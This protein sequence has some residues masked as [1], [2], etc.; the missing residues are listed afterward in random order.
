MKS[1][2]QSQYIQLFSNAKAFS[3]ANPKPIFRTETNLPEPRMNVFCAHGAS[4]RQRPERAAASRGMPARRNMKITKRTQFRAGK[5]RKS[6]AETRES[7]CR[8]PARLPPAALAPA[9]SPEIL[10]RDGVGLEALAAGGGGHAQALA[11]GGG[12]LVALQLLECLGEGVAR[13][14]GLRL[15]LRQ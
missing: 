10:D 15:G 12:D 7:A 4:R 1:T 9:R 8:S 6:R 2:N 14:R 11:A 5:V 13:L 3:K